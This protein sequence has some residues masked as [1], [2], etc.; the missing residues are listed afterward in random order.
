MR[1]LSDN[2]LDDQI[3]ALEASGALRLV[4]TSQG[5]KLLATSEEGVT[6]VQ[7]KKSRQ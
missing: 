4:Q 2:A 3:D 5:P 1:G 6:A 7:E